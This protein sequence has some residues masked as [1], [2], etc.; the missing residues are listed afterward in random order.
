MN[1]SSSVKALGNLY[2]GNLEFVAD[3]TITEVNC[4]YMAWIV[5]HL[6][7]L[8]RGKFAKKKRVLDIDLK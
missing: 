4:S 2:F 8:Q 6:K 1:F 7:F 3:D 5:V